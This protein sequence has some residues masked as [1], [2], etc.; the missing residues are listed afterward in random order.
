MREKTA[1]HEKQCD[2]PIWGDA[3]LP[4]RVFQRRYADAGLGIW[5]TNRVATLCKRL[6]WT[7]WMLC[8][9]AGMFKME[10]DAHTGEFELKLDRHWIKMCWSRDSWPCTVTVQFSNLE[11]FLDSDPAPQTLSFA[12]AQQECVAEVM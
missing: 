11:A 8:A 1:L 6:R 9:W 12:H 4:V 5:N 10:Y 3:S 7:P 2:V